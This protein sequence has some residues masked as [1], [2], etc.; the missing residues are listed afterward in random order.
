MSHCKLDVQYDGSA[1]NAE[2]LSESIQGSRA[3]QPAEVAVVLQAF[4]ADRQLGEG[5]V[6]AE[7]L[8][9]LLPRQQDIPMR[10]LAMD[11]V[12]RQ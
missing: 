6:P 11:K 10:L 1:A 7:L 12:D 4:H 2:L 3:N 8:L 5:G 9:H